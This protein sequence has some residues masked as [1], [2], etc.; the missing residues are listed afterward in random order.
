MRLAFYTLGLA[1][2]AAALG[3]AL[4]TQYGI[5]PLAPEVRT[6]MLLSLLVA[7]YIGLRV[8]LVIRAFEQRH[9]DRNGTGDD[10][11]PGRKRSAFN[12]WGR[13]SSLDAR[14][15]ARRERLRRAREVEDRLSESD[16]S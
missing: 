2:I 10:S 13:S 14:L 11:R 6:I 5:D 12:R 7:G 15:E 9:A 3:Y 1:A 4:F 8:A 16:T